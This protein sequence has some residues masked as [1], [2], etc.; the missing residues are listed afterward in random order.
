M[1]EKLLNLAQVAASFQVQLRGG[2]GAHIHERE[3]RQCVALDKLLKIND[4]AVACGCR[5]MDATTE[6]RAR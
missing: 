5:K 2:R 3:V 4:E 1:L 6:E